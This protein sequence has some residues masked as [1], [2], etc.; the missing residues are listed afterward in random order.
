M[1]IANRISTLFALALASIAASY[2][3]PVTY[4]IDS[5]HTYPRFSYSH[6]GLSTQLSSFRNTSGTVV[7]DTASKTASVEVTIDMNSVNTGF[8]DFDGHLRSE[9]F[10]DTAKHPNATFKSTR[11][12]FAG[13]TPTLIEGL[14]TIRGITKPVTLTVSSFLSMEHPMAKKPA[15]GANA[16]TNIKRSDFDAGKYAPYV[17]DD[18]RIDIA[19]EAIA[20]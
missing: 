12:V 13:E 16:Y 9:D 6:F 7:L 17:S 15:I 8:V 19:L 4:Q 20:P 3:A 14:L 10:F 18:V 5:T 2:A 1:N 11:V